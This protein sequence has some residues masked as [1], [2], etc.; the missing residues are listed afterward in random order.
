MSSPSQAVVQQWLEQLCR[1]ISGIQSAIVIENSAEQSAGRML[2]R[3]P[4]DEEPSKTLLKVALKAVETRRQL[5]VPADAKKELTADLM[6]LPLLSDGQPMG[7]VAIRLS[8]RPAQKQKAAMQALQWSLRWLK[9]LMEQAN[10][11]HT[12]GTQWVERL[13]RKSLSPASIAEL[14][15]EQ[16]TCDR[17]TLAMG[18]GRR[19]EIL[20]TQ[21]RVEIKRETGLVRTFKEAMFEAMDQHALLHYPPT[22]ANS[23]LVMH[24]QQNL[25]EEV[26]QATL[27][28]IPLVAT[29]KP[30]GALLLECHRQQPFTEQ[31]QAECQQAAGLV[32]L[33]LYH[34]QQDKR[35]L[36]GLMWERLQLQFRQL[37]GPKGLWLKVAVLVITLSIALLA[38]IDG[39]Y[40]IDARAN[41]E[42]RIQRMITSPF[43][44][45]LKQAPV[46]AGD[47]VAE[48]ALLCQLDDKDLQL[49]QAKWRTELAKLGK[50]QREALAT[51]ERAKVA[52][53]QA[54]QQQAQAELELVEKKLARSRITAP[55]HG[56]IVSGDLSQSLGA[57]LK[58]GEEL[59]KIAP[60]ESYRVMLQVDELDIGDVQIG[61]AGVLILAGYPQ[62][63]HTF[64]V[65]RILPLSSA[66]EGR[67]LFTL[68]AVL[69]VSNEILRPGLQGIAKIDA[70]EHSLLWLVSHRLIDW[71]RLQ[72]WRWW[73]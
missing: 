72:L 21:P 60:L 16:F 13:T 34:R 23:D 26:G 37:L 27:C 12:T 38:L 7:S 32:G 73:G 3:W 69:D 68:E 22:S 24:C 1:L 59:F 56:V 33:L 43:D 58:R 66:V 19:L 50:E 15:A 31:E 71:L 30:V 55:L 11:S 35:P 25:A 41:L 70:G 64:H 54:Q 40:R 46:K 20:A 18:D 4:E 9:L 52:I 36:T 10:R 5:I 57:P 65:K 63:E 28:S 39:D 8:A 29:D 62:L 42:G 48:G 49:E 14:L 17:V 2:V 61:Q 53:L 6:A 45:Y 51:H 67:Y 47:I 44:G